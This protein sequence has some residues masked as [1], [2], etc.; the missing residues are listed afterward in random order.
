MGQD[1]GG[2][3]PVFN[4]YGSIGV[5]ADP[6]V[7][8]VLTLSPEVSTA[9]SL[10]HSAL[11]TAAASQRDLN[12]SVQVQTVRQLRQG[13]APN[14]WEV[15]W[16]F[17]H[18]TDNTHF[19]YFILKPNGWELG[20]EDPSYPGNQRFLATGSSPALAVGSWHSID[21]QQVG[22]TMT[23]SVDGNPVVTFTDTQ[24]PYTSGSVGLYC[25]DSVV[26]FADPIITPLP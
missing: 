20:K 22:A 5:T 9:P 19:Y 2:W 12:F 4:G 16:V 7:G 18:Y 1:Y 8:N 10:T 15:G 23:V 24:N 3:I 21:V 26:N 11:V 14:P 13:S 17:W 6:G 25:E